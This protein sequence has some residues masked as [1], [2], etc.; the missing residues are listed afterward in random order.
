MG[1]QGRRGR[2]LLDELRE[3]RRHH[4]LKEEPIERINK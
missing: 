1:R 3:T 4:N 2:Q